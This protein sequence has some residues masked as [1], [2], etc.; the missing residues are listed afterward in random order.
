MFQIADG[1]NIP[2]FECSC[3]QN[4]NV[5]DTFLVLARLVRQERERKS[6]KHTRKAVMKTRQTKNLEDS[7]FIVTDE[8]V[9]P[10]KRAVN[11]REDYKT[12][13][14]RPRDF[15]SPK[16]NK[17]QTSSPNLSREKERVSGGSIASRLR[18]VR[19]NTK[20]YNISSSKLTTNSSGSEETEI[21]PT[22]VTTSSQKS[23]EGNE[24]YFSLDTRRNTK[25]IK[26]DL[27]Q[28]VTNAMDFFESLAEED[29]E[30]AFDNSSIT[31]NGLIIEDKGLTLGSQLSN[32][33]TRV[34]PDDG[35][36]ENGEPEQSE[37]RNNPIKHHELGP[38]TVTKENDKLNRL[39]NW[40]KTKDERCSK[41]NEPNPEGNVATSKTNKKGINGNE[42]PE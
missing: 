36:N 20:Q 14:L 17:K 40:D 12:L 4:I 6:R 38:E 5:Q 29:I 28:V 39:D 24:E 34:N 8:G 35:A 31:Q 27:L 42:L 33:S 19:K 9:Q 32:K 13:A 37:E 3:K 22:S 23:K 10:R 21:K 26:R 41:D 15:V 2:F 30:Q 1:F 11:E 7:A 18:N 25:D 16:T